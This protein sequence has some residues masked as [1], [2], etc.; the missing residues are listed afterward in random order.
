MSPHALDDPATRYLELAYAADT[1]LVAHE[2]ARLPDEPAV[3]SNDQ[4]AEP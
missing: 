4:Y 3:V 1:I 2:P